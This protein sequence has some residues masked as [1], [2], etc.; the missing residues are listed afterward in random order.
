MEFDVFF[1]LALAMGAG[2]LFNRITKYI[3]LP[4]VT[5]YL[6][7]GLL[8]G[9]YVLK[10]VSFE[11]VESFS[12]ISSF[13]LGF[14]AFTIGNSFRIRD[15]KK[16]GRSVLTVTAFESMGA[17][18]LLD[19]VLI[20]CRFPVPMAITLGAMGSATAPA[21]TLLV[22]RQYKAKGPVTDMLLPVVALDDAVA[23]ICYSVSVSVA[24][25]MAGSEKAGVL[26]IILRP[27]L[28]I[29]L[30]L[31]V[32]AVIGV[33]LA[34]C[35]RIFHSR[36]NRLSCVVFAVTLGVALA[37]RFDLSALLLC[38]ME[39][40]VL[41]NLFDGADAIYEG[42][43]RWT[44]PLFM[45]FFV[46]SGAELN[47]TV[48]P[49]IGLLGALYIVVRCVGKYAGASLGARLEKHDKNVVRYLGV[50]LFPQ[51]G[52]AIGMSQLV[53]TELPLYGEQ[54][55]TVI[56]AA[57]LVYELIGPLL[58]KLVLTKAGEIQKEQRS[59]KGRASA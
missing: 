7:G 8:I 53:M 23:L 2:L 34:L 36:A 50:T 51:A 14:I 35:M 39:S 10:L 3:K 31:G 20:L 42:V 32:G 28:K 55:R 11:T 52:V 25:S 5:G 29:V 30:S 47:L 21:A 26:S 17:M 59:K 4:N 9:P 45:L 38:M 13:A 56:L 41:I 33:V 22:I 15:I 46:I 40:A 58:T 24:A 6:V 18:I 54:I 37:N 16:L 49:K 43:D 44:P 27:L 48:L 12:V 1:Y 19:I 57:T